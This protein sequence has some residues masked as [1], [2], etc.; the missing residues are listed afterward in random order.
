MRDQELD[1]FRSHPGG[2]DRETFGQVPDIIAEYATHRDLD[3]TRM[4]VNAVL[5]DGRSVALASARVALTY[6]IL[7]SEEDEMIFVPYS[8]IRRIETKR[9]AR[10][11]PEKERPPIG[12]WVERVDE[13]QLPVGQRDI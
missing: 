1:Y 5:R 8:E 6:V 7:F 13:P 4:V 9:R 10:P 12:F 2:F 11:M 3:Y